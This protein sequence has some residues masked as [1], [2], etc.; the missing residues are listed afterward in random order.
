MKVKIQTLYLIKL[1]SYI[2]ILYFILKYL[3]NLLFLLNN[4]FIVILYNMDINDMY[5]NDLIYYKQIKQTN[6]R[7]T[8]DI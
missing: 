6:I 3:S 1:L 5:V 2:I 8:S 4:Y 7:D